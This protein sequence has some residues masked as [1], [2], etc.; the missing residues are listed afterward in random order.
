MPFFSSTKTPKG[1][2]KKHH[3]YSHGESMKQMLR[4]ELRQDAARAGAVTPHTAADRHAEE[5][6]CKAEREKIHK[7]KNWITRSKTFQ[8]IVEGAY[9]AVDLDSNGRL[10]AIEIYAAVL[11][12]AA[13]V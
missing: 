10:S 5:A 13:R 6:Q 2:K 4:D 7:K 11:F 1:Q 3:K 8:K 12:R 9:N